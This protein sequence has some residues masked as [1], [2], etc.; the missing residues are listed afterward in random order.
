VNDP[1]DIK[2]Y[3]SDAHESDNH[4]ISPVPLKPE[5]RR[6]LSCNQYGQITDTLEPRQQKSDT[7]P[8]FL[9]AAFRA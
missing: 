3:S 8:L 1:S 7:R 2:N 9:Y 5:A 6:L 4:Y